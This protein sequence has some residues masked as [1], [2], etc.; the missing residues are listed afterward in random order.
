MTNTVH[1][2][3]GRNKN[4]VHQ[5]E[6]EINQSRLTSSKCPKNSPRLTEEN[7]E[8]HQT[9]QWRVENSNW[10]LHNVSAC[11]VAVY[12]YSAKGVL[13]YNPVFVTTV[14]KAID[15]LNFSYLLALFNNLAMAV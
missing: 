5:N 10:N 12:N 15:S 14:T 4:T 8:N 3:R 6:Q 2:T 11:L 1:Y 7:Q 13:S 9:G